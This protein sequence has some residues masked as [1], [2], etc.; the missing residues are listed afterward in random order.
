MKYIQKSEVDNRVTFWSKVLEIKF[1]EL[2]TATM[3][4]CVT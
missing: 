2:L 1:H 4:C 3:V